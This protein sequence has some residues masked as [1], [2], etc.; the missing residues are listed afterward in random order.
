MS[1]DK[2]NRKTKKKGKDLSKFVFKA[3][4]NV[5]IV[6]TKQKAIFFSVIVLFFFVSVKIFSKFFLIKE[7]TMKRI[8]CEYL[9][10]RIKFCH[11]TL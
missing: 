1:V 3:L 9:P 6:L 2:E 4:T 7:L 5:H 8:A 10:S 11:H